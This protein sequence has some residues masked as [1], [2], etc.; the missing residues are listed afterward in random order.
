MTWQ[1]S[2]VAQVVWGS[3]Q[4]KCIWSQ[5]WFIIWDVG[6]IGVLKIDLKIMLI[7]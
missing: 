5:Q 6:Y 4:D 7:T 2:D 3:G 1:Y